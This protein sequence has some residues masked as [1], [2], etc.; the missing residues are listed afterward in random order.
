MNTKLLS[1][2]AAINLAI[3][4]AASAQSESPEEIIVKGHRAYLSDFDSL[5]IPQSDTI[6]DAEL[7][8][9]AGVLDL[10]QALDLSAS[11]ARQNNFGGLWNAFSVRG[12]RGAL[13]GRGEPGGTVNL[14]TKRPEFET[15]GDFQAAV[16]SWDLARVSGDWQTT[17]G[18]NDNV[19]IRLVGFIEDAGSFRQTVETQ[20][21][22]FYPSVYDQL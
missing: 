10:N 13:F 11:V 22:G 12:S 20:K 3:T 2:V 6:L 14:I 18:E 9:D 1:L 7:L 15:S 21:V 19:G 5:E 17:L 16:G 4:G 8:Q